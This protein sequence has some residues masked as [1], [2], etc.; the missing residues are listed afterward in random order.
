MR[1]NLFLKKQMCFAIKTNALLLKQMCEQKKQMHLHMI[2]FA[3]NKQMCSHPLTNVF[4][5]INKCIYSPTNASLKQQMYFIN[6]V[7]A[8]TYQGR[9]QRALAAGVLEV[10]PRCWLWVV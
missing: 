2:K 5:T 6:N 1:S 7:L 9:P 4:A 3:H 10:L 8:R